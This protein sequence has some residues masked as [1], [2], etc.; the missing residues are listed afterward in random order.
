[1]LKI[2]TETVIENLGA[3]DKARLRVDV[4]AD[5]VLCGSV[6]VASGFS[7]ETITDLQN[8]VITM[9][10]LRERFFAS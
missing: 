2:T 9:D 6:T 3:P 7:L 4:F 8:G 1:M 10:Q 5:G